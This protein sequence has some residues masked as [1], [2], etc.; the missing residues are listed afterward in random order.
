MKHAIRGFML[1]VSAILISPVFTTAQSISAYFGGGSATAPSVGSINTLGAGT[2]Y[3]APSMSGFFETFGADV[4]FFHNLGVGVELS[5]RNGRAPYAGLTYHPS[6]YDANLV[7]RP[8]TL[9]HR[10]APEI[11]AG[12]GESDL[13]FYYTSTI[14]YKLPQGCSGVNT[15]AFSANNNQIHAAFGARFYAYRGLFVR[16]QFDFRYVQGNFTTY[17]G[18]SWVPQYSVAIG[19]TYNL[20]SKLGKGK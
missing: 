1:L 14:C 3:Q 2:F 4:I 8:R 11:Q 17:F 19:Y 13:N 15:E 16:P 20:S 7:Y 12:F 6:F 9:A 18:R 5:T 10:I